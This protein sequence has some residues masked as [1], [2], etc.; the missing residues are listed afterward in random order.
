[1]V[2]ELRHAP[3]GA[4]T[5]GILLGR[6]ETDGTAVVRHAGEPGPAAVQSPT[7]F[8]RDLRHAQTFADEAYLKDGSVWI[9]EWHSHPTSAPKPS[10]QDLETYG[11][12]IADSEL[13]LDTVIAVIFGRI[14]DAAQEEHPGAWAA[15]AW[16][17]DGGT[18]RQLAMQ[19]YEGGR[20]T[21]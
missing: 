6:L 19:I 1:M 5:G 7:F 12:L 13:Q 14:G 20:E 11:A 21:L 8:L 3:A 16:S 9:G 4:E 2:A 17:Y 18:L 10:P 15:A